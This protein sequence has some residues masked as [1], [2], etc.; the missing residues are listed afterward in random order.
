[1]INDDGTAVIMVLDEDE[2]ED[3]EEKVLSMEMFEKARPG[4]NLP[5]HLVPRR[6]YLVSHS[7]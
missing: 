1:M 2:D 5:G 4:D 3:A 7:I 6:G